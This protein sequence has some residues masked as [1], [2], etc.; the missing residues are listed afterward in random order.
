ML[1]LFW[2]FQVMY[3]HLGF[4][5]ERPDNVGVDLDVLYTR[6]DGGVTTEHEQ[7]PSLLWA[8]TNLETAEK[9]DANVDVDDDA[10]FRIF[11]F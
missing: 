5:E 7:S 9:E 3:G 4:L 2:F 11:V 10:V 6:W 1:S 8:M